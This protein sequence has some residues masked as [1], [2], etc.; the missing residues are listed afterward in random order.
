MPRNL[1]FSLKIHKTSSNNSI[2][3][4]KLKNDIPINNPKLP[5][6]FEIKSK[7]SILGS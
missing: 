4:A 6:I 3:S 2:I 5:P 1:L 7:K